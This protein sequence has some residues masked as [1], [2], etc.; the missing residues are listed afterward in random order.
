MIFP[1]IF[2]LNLMIFWLN[3]MIFH[4]FPI[5]FLFFAN[6]HH[7]P[8]IFLILSLV[9][10]W[11]WITDSGIFLLTTITHVF[12]SL[13]ELRIRNQKKFTRL[14]IARCTVHGHHGHHSRRIW[15]LV[16][17]RWAMRCSCVFWTFLS[18][19]TPARL[20]C[21]VLLVQTNLSFLL[22]QQQ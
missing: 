6:F 1:K 4:F 17:F 7:F 19:L 10:R 5:F 22:L 11:F 16:Q 20:T 13:A 12:S 3:L 18:V 2:L 14:R 15:Q 9:L 8:P 21:T